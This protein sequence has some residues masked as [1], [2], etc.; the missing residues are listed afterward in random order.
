MVEALKLSGDKEWLIEECKKRCI[1]GSYKLKYFKALK[2]AVPKEE[3]KVFLNELWDEVDW[4]L[5]LARFFLSE[6]KGIT[7]Q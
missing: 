3:W 6:C 5:S 7:K 2:E 4:S 1:V